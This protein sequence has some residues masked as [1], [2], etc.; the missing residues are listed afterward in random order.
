MQICG[1]QEAGCEAAVHAMSHIF[2]E[3]DT[4]GALLVDA[5]NAFNLCIWPSAREVQ[6]SNLMRANEHCT[7]HPHVHV[8]SSASPFRQLHSS[9]ICQQHC[10]HIGQLQFSPIGHH[11]TNPTDPTGTT[12]QPQTNPTGQKQT[13]PTGQ[14]TNQTSKQQKQKQSSTPLFYIKQKDTVGP[15]MCIHSPIINTCCSHV[16]TLVLRARPFEKQG[17]GQTRIAVWFLHV[18]EFLGHIIARKISVM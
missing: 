8:L 17:S 9:L 16:C 4:E 12:G 13:K 7:K 5:T 2:S 11:H 14:Q 18:Q 3:A 1:G 15:G 6:C 10:S